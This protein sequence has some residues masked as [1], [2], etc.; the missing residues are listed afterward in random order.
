M[1]VNKDKVTMSDENMKEGN[2][3]QLESM[4]MTDMLKYST[5]DIYIKEPKYE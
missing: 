2:S 3:Q 4:N 1:K 5:V